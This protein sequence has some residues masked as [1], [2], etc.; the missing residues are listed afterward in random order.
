MAAARILIGVCAGIAAV[1]EVNDMLGVRISE[2][3][4]AEHVLDALGQQPV[5][6]IVRDL[7]SIEKIVVVPYTETA[8]DISGIRC[9]GAYQ[10][11]RAPES[12]LPIRFEQLPFGSFLKHWRQ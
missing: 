1:K 2:L 7:P 5:A 10:A 9:A 8:P 4:A 11:F 12:G 3:G 6:E